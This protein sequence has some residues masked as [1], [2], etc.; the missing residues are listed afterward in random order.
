MGKFHWKIDVQVWKR[1]EHLKN[2]C[3][4]TISL[5]HETVEFF[6][7]EK[8][9]AELQMVSASVAQ[10]DTFSRNF[11]ANGKT[12]GSVLTKFHSLLWI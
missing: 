12:I 1:Y 3:K 10:T 6:E 2:I 11:Q 4:Q 7:A 5:P 9:K 8:A